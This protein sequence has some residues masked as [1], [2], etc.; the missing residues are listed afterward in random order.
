MRTI[1]RFTSVWSK[2]AWIL[3]A[4]M[5][6]GLP[7]VAQS[8]PEQLVLTNH[9]V[10]EKC[11]RSSRDEPRMQV[12]LD[13]QTVSVSYSQIELNCCLQEIVKSVDREAETIYV[14]AVQTFRSPSDA[15]RCQCNYEVSWAFKLP[16]PGIYTL[17][18]R[19]SSDGMNWL[20]V[21]TSNLDAST[22]T[23]VKFP[24]EPGDL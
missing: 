5:E 21:A 22:A 8:A 24:T 20:T 2:T 15:C 1:A 19:T 23:M 11:T 17:V 12:S 18:L 6:L 9:S 7:A 16:A 13:G 4:I 14:N 3:M 10:G